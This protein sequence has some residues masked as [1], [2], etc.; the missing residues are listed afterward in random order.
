[1]FLSLTGFK[2]IRINQKF[3]FQVNKMKLRICAKSAYAKISPILGGR[4][5]NLTIVYEK[6]AFKS[7]KKCLHV[8]NKHSYAEKWKK[9]SFDQLNVFNDSQESRMPLLEKQ[10]FR[11]G[12]LRPVFSLNHCRE[13]RKDFL[14][15]NRCYFLFRI[16]IRSQAKGIFLI[17]K[18]TLVA[19]L[20]SIL[21]FGGSP[22]GSIDNTKA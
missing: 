14:L 19:L 10:T 16:W 11:A 20:A 8:G 21:Y 18:I 15:N 17:R 1:M 12:W 3:C 5:S 7:K 22:S 13:R 4:E 9:T 6:K 2:R